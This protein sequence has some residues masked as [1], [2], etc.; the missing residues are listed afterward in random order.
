MTVI[1]LAR[2]PDPA[3][4]CSLLEFPPPA[5]SAPPIVH[6][7][8]KLAVAELLE[9]SQAPTRPI[10]DD[11][12]RRSMIEKGTMTILWGEA[13][14]DE[15]F[16]PL[17]QRCITNAGV[18]SVFEDVKMDEIKHE[19]EIMTEPDTNES[20]QEF[21][22]ARIKRLKKEEMMKLKQEAARLKEETA[23]RLAFWQHSF[24]RFKSK[25]WYG[26]LTD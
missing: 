17:V 2:V 25:G 3:D 15:V 13:C 19:N 18:K 26:P 9:L 1:D 10:F 16:R 8:V 20:K 6:K 22:E 23:K 4:F 12:Y 14:E 5:P 21:E 7:P 24:S 11:L